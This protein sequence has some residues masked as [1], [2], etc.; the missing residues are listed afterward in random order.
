MNNDSL[1]DDL[2]LI[3][4]KR[5]LNNLNEGLKKSSDKKYIINKQK[6]MNSDKNNL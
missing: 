2:L 6:I 1:Y 3:E 5:I 4:G